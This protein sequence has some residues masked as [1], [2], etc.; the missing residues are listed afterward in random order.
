MT[1]NQEKLH[2]FLSSA[3]N[4]EG[5]IHFLAISEVETESA[6][7]GRPIHKVRVAL[8]Y[9]EG[10][11]IT[12]YFDG[13][14]VFVVVDGDD[15]SFTREEEWADGPPLVEGSPNELA[16]SWV[17]ELAEPFY[18]S[19]EARAAATHKF[20]QPNNETGQVDGNSEEPF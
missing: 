16:L 13:T 20:Y 17:S 12:P 15:I 11:E 1:T 2:K 6:V 7:K 14:D 3:F 4:P 19:A 5:D 10:D 18:I 9:K 8:T